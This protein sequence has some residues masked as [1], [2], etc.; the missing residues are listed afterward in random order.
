MP[1][2]LE[3]RRTL[4]L[5]AQTVSNL[6]PLD[7]GTM[8]TSGRFGV[9]RVDLATGETSWIDREF[10]RCVNLTVDEPSG[11][12]FCGDPYGRLDERRL[13]DGAVMRR[14]DAQNG[15]SGSLWIASEATELVSFGNN[16]PVVSRWRLD[17]SG[18]ITHL[19]APGGTPI[20]FNPTGDLLYVA[21]GDPV[22]RRLRGFGGRCQ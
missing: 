21:R 11:A 22:R 19:A 20:D 16:E 13:T 8:I 12:A 17:R 14:L 9:A 15:N 4:A 5:E 1:D 10:E 3:V 18:P 7:D 6:W 2:S